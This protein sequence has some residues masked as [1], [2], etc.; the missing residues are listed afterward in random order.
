MS[1][2]RSIIENR[3]ARFKGRESRS[4]SIA[5]RFT[6]AEAKA[7]ARKAEESGQ[8][9]RE[10]AREVLLRELRGCAS[11]PL[12]PTVLTEIVGLHLF[13]I[14]VLSPIARGERI[15]QEHYQEILRH[16]REHKHVAAAEILGSPAP[17]PAEVQ[18]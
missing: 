12:D 6:P 9:L 4:Q 3:F 10:W 1:T 5:T 18:K 14:N 16:V 17:G 11:A 7:L 13:L 15:T 2:E 8:N